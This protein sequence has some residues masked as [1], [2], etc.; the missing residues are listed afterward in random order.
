MAVRARTFDFAVELDASG[1]VSGDRGGTPLPGAERD[2]WTPEH[3]VL[4]G[5]ARCTVASFAFHA[6]RAGLAHRCA[7][8]ATG[9]VTRR[10]SDGRYAFVEIAVAVEATLEP[11][12]EPAELAELLVRAKRDCFVGA[13]LAIEPTTTWTVNGR[14]R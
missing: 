7:A 2:A 5:L 12:P 10:E 14:Q 11:E 3:L 13:S 6:E 9:R 1:E 4:A 8:S